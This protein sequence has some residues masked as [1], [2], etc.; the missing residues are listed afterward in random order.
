MVS[1]L[2]GLLKNYGWNFFFFAIWYFIHEVTHEDTE[3]ELVCEVNEN[4]VTGEVNEFLGF[5]DEEIEL[6]RDKANK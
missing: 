5:T 1:F 3:M 6:S 2:K 4:E